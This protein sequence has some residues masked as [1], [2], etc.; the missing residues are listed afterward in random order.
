MALR[1]RTWCW[2]IPARETSFCRP[3]RQ[4]E[5]HGATVKRFDPRKIDATLADLRKAPPRFV[6]FVLP[7]EKIDVELTHAILEM[8]TQVDDDPFVDFEYGFVTGRDGAAALRFVERIAAAWKRDFGDKA[9]LFAS[10]EGPILP[11]ADQLTGMKALGFSATQRL[12]KAGD[13]AEVRL[14]ATREFLTECKGKDA[15]IFMSHGYPDRMDL[16]FNA[17][18]LRDWKVDLSP[19]I[20]FNCACFN[21]APGHWFHPKGQGYEDRGITARDQSVALALLDSGIAGYFAG[22]DVWH[23]PL[24]SQVFYYVTDDGMRLGEAANAMHNRLATGVSAR[25]HPLRAD[26]ERA[27][28]RQGLDGQESTP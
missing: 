4:W 24:N 22:V 10:W 14:K 6:V 20:L 5:L 27:T 28:W 11:P 25:A 1:A 15:L 2:S 17:K 7:P 13:A 26:D 18:N 12:V 19:A 3:P 23:G 9:T 16:C 8:A 21:G